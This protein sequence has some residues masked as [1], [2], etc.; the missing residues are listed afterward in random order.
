MESVAPFQMPR[1]AHSFT[2]FCPIDENGS[3]DIIDESV[4]TSLLCTQCQQ[5][6]TWLQSKL[7]RLKNKGFIHTTRTFNHHASGRLLEEAHLHGCHLCTI[8][9]N[10]FLGYGGPNYTGDTKK[11]LRKAKDLQIIL[12]STK[13]RPSSNYSLYLSAVMRS[14]Y[15]TSSS[16]LLQLVENSGLSLKAAQSKTDNT[17]E[18]SQEIVTHNAVE[19]STRGGLRHKVSQEVKSGL[20]TTTSPIKAVPVQHFSLPLKTLS[21]KVFQQIT[22][23]IQTCSASHNSCM[24]ARTGALPT[25][26]I[27]LQEIQQHH[28][29]RVVKTPPIMDLKNATLSYCWGG[30]SKLQL[31]KSNASSLEAGVSVA[32]LPKTI[33]DA[34]Y[35]TAKLGLRWLWVDSLCIFQDSPED[36]AHE[37]GC[38]LDRL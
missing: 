24:A 31:H 33:Q 21:P 27:D 6:R 15:Q 12:K 1:R 22:T 17:T 26:L 32:A 36:M 30:K 25:R 5:I 38:V 3:L 37:I 34:A 13:S 7:Y 23:W 16:L 14:P 4:Q 29:V 35:F 8:I 28:I 10:D 9:W 19:N 20:Y 18:E 11:V 2:E